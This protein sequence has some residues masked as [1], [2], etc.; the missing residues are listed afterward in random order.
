MR[1]IDKN[2][3]WSF[4]EMGT[5]LIILP[6]GS[7]PPFED[8]RQ[9]ESPLRFDGGGFGAGIFVNTAS[10]GAPN[11]DGFIYVY[12]VRGVEKKLMVA[13]VLPQDFENFDA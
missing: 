1:T 11:P 13:R 2:D 7:T 12:G 6:S 8:Q 3:D 9:I 5:D 4:K 10:S